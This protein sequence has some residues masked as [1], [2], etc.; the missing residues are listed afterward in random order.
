[1]RTLAMFSLLCCGYATGG[2]HEDEEWIGRYRGDANGDSTVNISDPIFLGNYLYSSGPVPP[3][4]NEADANGDGQVDGADVTFLYDFLMSSG[5]AP[6]YPGPAG[7]G[8]CVQVANPISCAYL[9]C[10]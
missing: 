9:D 3:C 5:S 8:G 6:P 10:N 7:V 4:F 2:I 1:M